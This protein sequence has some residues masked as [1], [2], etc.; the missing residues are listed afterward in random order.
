[1]AVGE[2]EHGIIYLKRNLCVERG[3]LRSVP[4]E[5][6]GCCCECWRREV[7]VGEEDHGIYLSSMADIKT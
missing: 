6:A 4:L 3:E 1:V 7:A 2:E 5:A